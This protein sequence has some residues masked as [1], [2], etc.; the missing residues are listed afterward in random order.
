[1]VYLNSLRRLADQQQF[2]KLKANAQALWSENGQ[3]AALPLLAL[4][5]AKLG[6]YAEASEVCEQV[7]EHMAALDWDAQVDLAG[8]HCVLLRW[9]IALPILEAVLEHQPDHA[10]ALARLAWCRIGE[11]RLAEARQLYLR[12]ATL[13]PHR[14]TVWFALTRLCLQQ[15]DLVAAQQAH[16]SACID[17]PELRTELA[18]EFFGQLQALQ[19]EIWVAGGEIAEAEQWLENHHPSLSEA[20]WVRLVL[21]FTLQLAGHDQHAAADDFLRAGQKH[22]PENL[23]L[24]FQMVDLAQW[25]GQLQQAVC[26]LRRGIALA[27]KQGLPEIGWWVRLSG[28]GLYQMEELAR[29]AAEKAIEQAETLQED[30][31]TSTATIQMARWQAKSAL[32]QVESQDQHFALAEALFREVLAENPWFLPALQGLGQQQM[33]RGHIEEAVALFERVKEIDPAKGYSALINAHRFPE[34]KETLDRLEW[35]A[36]QPGLA[37]RSQPGL[38]LQ[39]A[40]AWEKHKDYEK[41]FALAAEANLASKKFLS[42]D[43]KAHRQSCARI[44]HAFCKELYEHRRGC[45]VASR[46]PVFVLG[47]PRSGTT[48]IEQILA[49]HSQICGAGEL[50]VIPV[51][52]QGL[53]R[54][55]RHTGSAR[56]YPDCIDDLNAHAAQGVADGI[57]EE[58]QAFD[59]DARHVVDK[60]PHNFENIGLIKFLFPNARIISVRRDPRDIAISNYF[61]DYQAKFGGMGFAY[62]LTWIGE[63]LADHNLLMQHWHQLFPGEILEINYEDVVEDTEAMARKML[64]YIGVDWEPQVLN[65][66]ALDR[67]VKTASVWQVRQPIYKTSKARWMHYEKHLAPLIQGTNGKIT[68]DAIDMVTLPEAGLLTDGVAFYKQQQFAQAEL[69]FKKLLHHIPDHAAANY[70]LGLIYVQSDDIHNGVK[71]MEKAV[72]QCPWKADWREDLAKAFELAGWP[73]NAAGLRQAREPQTDHPAEAGL[74]LMDRSSLQISGVPA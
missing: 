14:F 32:A 44:R 38:L 56:S 57:I 74:G 73:E 62:D 47:M 34:D 29:H 18:A 8:V 64:D 24:I 48:L 43:P 10:L 1:M 23:D 65:F 3:L 9:P 67:P 59:P 22:Y 21:G 11:G 30:E 37:G 66:N 50:G 46:L 7:A 2:C 16:D 45:G 53:N 12:S 51:R 5:H 60:L 31:Q 36:R 69:R 35:M 4:A 28:V 42:Y 13:A 39:L 40:S 68:W 70:M 63:Q 58:L 41:A 6:E 54:W 72:L 25:Q 17:P 19:L 49:G 27:R 71:L 26:L 20:A 61:M 52:I 33:Q 55:E 15:G